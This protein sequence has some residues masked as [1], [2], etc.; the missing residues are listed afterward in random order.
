MIFTCGYS[1][2]TYTAMPAMQAAA[3]DRHE[4]RVELAA[5][6]A[7]DLHAD[8][9]LAG[10]HV[11]IVERMHEHQAALARER[12]RVLVGAVVVVA[13]QH[14]LAA[15]VAHR[16]HLDVRRGLRHDDDGAGCRAGCAASATPC[17]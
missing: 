8:R 1:Y 14:H 2:F 15:E 13:V 10:D 12:Q 17:A 5:A 6:L 3:A 4:D 16:L 9:A 11:R 7:Q